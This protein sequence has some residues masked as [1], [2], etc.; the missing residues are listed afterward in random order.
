MSWARLAI[1]GTLT[2]FLA[3]VLEPL[4]W[5]IAYPVSLIFAAIVITQSLALVVSWLSRWLPCDIASPNPIDSPTLPSPDL[6]TRDD[7]LPPLSPADGRAAANDDCLRLPPDRA[8][9]RLP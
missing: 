8:G 1:L 4:L 7:R 9:Q 2:L 5:E 3:L 6:G